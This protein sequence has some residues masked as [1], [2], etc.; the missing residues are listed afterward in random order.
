MIFILKKIF[1]GYF[2]LFF[3]SVFIE[4]YSFGYFNAD[5]CAKSIIFYTF[6]A[7][8]TNM[9]QITIKVAWNNSAFEGL[10]SS[11]TSYGEMKIVTKDFNDIID[12]GEAELKIGFDGYTEFGLELP[13]WYKNKEYEFVYKFQDVTAMLKAYSSYVSL[14]AISRETGINSALL[15]HYANGLKVPRNKQ[16]KIIVAGLHRIGALLSKCTIDDERK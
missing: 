10:V 3:I 2:L 8:M 13:E 12:M 14:A 16:Q 1:L 11:E 9:K 4:K 15:S 6:A 5:M 7:K